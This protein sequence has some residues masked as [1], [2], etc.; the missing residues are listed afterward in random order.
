MFSIS[1]NSF[2]Y[3]TID[4]FHF[5]CPLRNCFRLTVSSSRK[6]IPSL[7]SITM[8][9]SL[10]DCVVCSVCTKLNI[11]YSDMEYCIFFIYSHE[12]CLRVAP[13]QY[14]SDMWNW[15]GNWRVENKSNSD[16]LI[17]TH[18]YVCVCEHGKKISI[19]KSFFFFGDRFVGI[20]PVSFFYSLLAECSVDRCSSFMCINR[21]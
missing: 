20:N 6:G 10:S 9:L 8:W 12:N 7:L 3:S 18:I 16:R 1:W 5:D 17:D 19:T 21:L 11:I 14:Q 2:S 15:M 4:S 13:N